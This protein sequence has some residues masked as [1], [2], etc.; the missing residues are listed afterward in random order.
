MQKLAELC[1]RR[2]VFA[3][4][5]ILILTVVG[6]AGFMQLGVDRFPQVDLPTVSIRASL[7][8][9]APETVETEVTDKIEEAVNTI[10]GVEELRSTSSEGSSNVTVTFTLET[11]ID[12]AT[13]DVRDRVALVQAQLPDEVEPPTV[14]R[15]DPN[16]IP[17][18][19]IAVVGERSTGD[20]T[21]YADKTLRRQIENAGGVGEV[22]LRGD[23]A[24]QVN[25]HLD[26]NRMRAYNLTAPD[27]IA[28]LQEQN[29]EIPG[30]RIEQA[31]QNQTLRT[32]ARIQSIE[33]FNRI[34]L[35]TGGGVQVRLS[36]VARVEDGLATEATSS[37]Y[38][39][40]PAVQMSIYKQ[41]G[42]NTLE[43]IE[44]VKERMKSLNATL[45]KDLELHVVRSQDEF[46][47]A[48]IH[49]VE[50]HLILGSI[51]ASLV[52]LAFL[53]NWRS[54]LISAIA[55]PTSLIATFG[56]MWA[57]GFTLNVI[58][59]LALTL[60][61]GIVIDDAIVVLENIYRLMEEK[62]MPPLQA[63][64]EGTREIGF[65]VLATTLSLVAVFLPV[66]FMSGIVG[67]FL[68]SFGLTMSFAILVS[69]VV[70]FTLTPM[71]TARWLGRK[72]AKAG[73]SEVKVQSHNSHDTSSRE[74]GIYGIVDKTYTGM[75]KW[76]MAHRW[77]VMLICGGVLFSIPVLWKMLPY[78]F[79]PEE[80]E[81]QF[82]VSLEAPQGTSL[83]VTR[84]KAQIIDAELR[85]L[86]EVEYTLLTAGGSGFGAG[87]PNEG[88]IYVRLKDVNKRKVP[89]S[90]V[91]QR[92]RRQ[93]GRKMRAMNLEARVSP[94]NSFGIIGGRGG[95]SRIQYVLSG[96]DLKVLEE[97][98]E[99]AVKEIEKVPGVTDADTSLQVGQPEVRVEIDRDMAGELGVRPAVLS[100]TLRYLVGGQRVTDYVEGGE[101][102]EVHIRSDLPFRTNAEGIGQLTVPVSATAGAQ[103][104][105]QAS[106]DSS[107]GGS[108]RGSVPL[109]QVV[110]FKRG[111]GPSSIE[112]YNR[113]RQI[114]LTA[115]V[116]PDASEAAIGA[117]VE[118]IANNLNLGPEY[119]VTASGSSR[120]QQRTNNAFMIAL[121]MSF[122]FMYLI[123]AAQFESWIHPITIL[124]T[125]PLTV[126]F[127]LLSLLLFGQTLNIFSLLGVLVLF[128]VVKKNAI[129]Q[130]DHTNQLR[131]KGLSRYDAIIEANRDRLRPILMTT[132]AF[133]AGMV[134]LVMSTGAGAGTNRAIGTVI[135]GGQSL[136]LLLTLLAVPVVYSL[137]DDLLLMVAN[138]R[139]RFGWGGTTDDFA[140]PN[141]Q[142]P[143]TA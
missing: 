90:E 86:P 77:A 70:S 88:N 43:V 64:I 105:A 51:L 8:G 16:Q 72:K 118:R 11:N 49:S 21:Q 117:A 119:Q 91:I 22:Q 76:S 102:Y 113:R 81:S 35:L 28:A 87:S 62:D 41:S 112:R 3:S 109:D 42:T 110:R 125:L 78:N 130:I 44:N 69:L 123:L 31:D 73:Q 115:N 53:W 45:P 137:L 136:S 98:A 93:M 103:A 106:T 80:D 37:E 141:D 83:D 75:L 47:K 23:R 135:F 10:A 65:A 67:R 124:L 5:L 74:R 17:V 14:R 56:M 116:E 19:A 82:Q 100:N 24:R 39:G 131:E 18:M 32:M 4:V 114:T 101:Q 142:R 52:V 58:T 61:V 127:A 134:P 46:I 20:L 138:A 104:A 79:L 29:I 38:N 92:V 12:V 13:Q 108:A 34:L 95:G 85:K 48:A 6:G 57:M 9:A 120:E 132:L 139:R 33:D 71:L 122:V 50:E 129:L 133:V 89:Q 1:V 128:G 60:A 27:V 121:A 126:P 99:R 140:Q 15:F 54:T 107:G 143:E 26:P 36:D 97:G 40:Q 25:I 7:P 59:L 55:I 2:P 30:G 111:T 63:A 84:R 96:P 94:I 68:A 66:A